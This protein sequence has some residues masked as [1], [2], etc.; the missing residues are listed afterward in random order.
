MYTKKKY[1]FTQMIYWT[2]IEIL[3]FL[4]L[5][6]LPAALFELAGLRWLQLPWTP[7]A[8]VGTAVA[9][10]IGFQNNAAYGRAWEARQIWGGI[11]NASRSWTVMVKD[12]VTNEYVSGEPASETELA[13]HQETLV[14]RHIAWLTALRFAM[15]QK[16]PWEVFTEHAT[17]KEW[18]EK[19][20]I[21]ERDGRIEDDLRPLL[22]EE[23]YKAV[24]SKTN[25]AA[26]ILT[27]QSAHLRA[28]KERGLIWEFSFLELEGLLREFFTLQGKS[29]RIKNFPY[30]RQYATLSYDIVRVFVVLLPFGVIPEFSKM[31]E[32]LSESFPLIGS[33]FIWMGVPFTMIV[34]WVFHTMQR[35][36]TV[37]ENPF[38]GS[39]ND[40]PISTMA[41]GIEIDLREMLDQDP[42]LI[43]KPLPV[44]E[45]V[46]M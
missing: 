32:S 44:V 17:N 23:E 46:Q 29:E 15:R 28:L 19:V 1:S 39:A 4:V 9:F 12:T 3:V 21:P 25:K 18:Y 35:I 8:L 38:E 43:P 2:R 10:L 13:A 42:A 31:G 11:V 33:L 26:A 16:R 5:A 7:I 20:C 37:G 24:L 30:P 41:R 40:V 22:P 36:G 6:L 34:S 27:L 14:Q 45:G